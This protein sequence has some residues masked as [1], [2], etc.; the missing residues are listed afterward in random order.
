MLLCEN[1]S[2]EFITPFCSAVTGGEAGLARSITI[3]QGIDVSPHFGGT[4]EGGH[5]P[6]P[7][8][9]VSK[10]NSSNT[11]TSI[12]HLGTDPASSPERK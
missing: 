11:Q 8:H 6:R 1:R 3:N 7:P 4:L 9:S 2:G 12:N 5:T 10:S